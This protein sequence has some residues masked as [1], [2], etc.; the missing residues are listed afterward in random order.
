MNNKIIGSNAIL[1]LLVNTSIDPTNNGPIIAPA[2]PNTLNS[3]KNSPDFSLGISFPNR[4]LE[5]P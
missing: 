2:L 1:I 4:P 3:P 5:L